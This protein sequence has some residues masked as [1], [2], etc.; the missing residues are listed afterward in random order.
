LNRRLLT[1][2]GLAFAGLGLALIAGCDYTPPGR[3]SAAK[4]KLSM[5]ELPRSGTSRAGSASGGLAYR[6]SAEERKAILDSIITLIQRAAIQP[7]GEHFAQAVKKLNQYFD[8][9]PQSEYELGSAAREY[10][11]TQ[12]NPD[13]IRDL[14][15]TAWTLRDTRHIEDCMMYYGIANR[16]AGAGDNLTRARR[17]FD[18]VVRQ[19]ELVP[20]GSFGGSRLGPAFARPYDVLVRGMATESEGT[21]WSERAW[22]FLSL[23]R[24]LEIDAGL[25]TYTKGNAVDAMLP[26]QKDEAVP[27]RAQRPQVVWI[28][29]VLV[30][31]QVY[32]FDARLGLEVPGPGGQGVATLDQALA[33]ASI[34]ERMNV[35]GLAP[36]SASRATLLSSPT[37]V[38]ILI[39]SSPGYF[40]PKMRLLQRELAGHYR[41]ILFADPAEQRDHFAQALGGHAG[42]I[43][44]WEL[45]LTVETRL[46]RDPEYVNAIQN[47]L[48]WFRP[49][50][51]LIYARVKQLRGELTEAIEDYVKFRKAVNFPNVLNK[52]EVIARDVQAG[53]DIYATYYM[54]LAQ[55]ENNNRDQAERMF[56]QV[57]D[58][59]PE[60]RAGERNPY[61]YMFRWGANANLGRI[62]EAKH[63]DQAAID[64]YTRF[65]P[66][67]QHA[68]NLVRA[69]EIVWSQPLGPGK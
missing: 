15:G 38:G 56:V 59:L 32:L 69:R 60:P 68:G 55:L 10:L 31:G 39:D 12:L 54:A 37:K 21:G 16:V 67:P 43:T 7:G 4:G 57:L 41:A 30:D 29:G 63:N 42:A 45:P 50:F 47:S 28:C 53:L 62:H 8:G 35:P 44:L 46:F 18:W 61:Y 65:D 19:V 11:S 33:D 14:Q 5:P 26:P 36:Y 13:L 9:T 2:H 51:P 58:A 1:W 24:Q 66:T 17:V 64:Y 20:S 49:G 40:S 34:L 22:L 3:A 27:R 6:R 52:K 25:I 48:F 23:C